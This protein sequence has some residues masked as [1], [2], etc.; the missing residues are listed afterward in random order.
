MFDKYNIDLTLP[1]QKSDDLVSSLL[2][3]IKE[4]KNPLK[5]LTDNPSFDYKALSLDSRNVYQTFGKFSTDMFVLEDFMQKSNS[6]N[7]KYFLNV[8]V[9][10]LSKDSMWFDKSKVK[11]PNEESYIES[12]E[13][14]G[15]VESLGFKKYESKYFYIYIKDGC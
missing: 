15:R 2:P 10:V 14:I 5:I 3:L 11:N 7:P 6:K 12:M 13:T 1:K 4:C 8:N 9:I